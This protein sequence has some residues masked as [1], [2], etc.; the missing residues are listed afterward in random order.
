[1]AS[2]ISAL[3][4]PAE[5]TSRLDFLHESGL[6]YVGDEQAFLP[7]YQYHYSGRPA[8]STQRAHYYIPSQFNDSRSGLPGNDD[9][10]AMGSFVVLSTIGLFPV[11]GQDV[12]L[13]NPPFFEEVAIRN[14]MTGRTATI[15]NINFDPTYSNVYIQDVTR[16]GRPWTK[17][18]ISHDFFLYGG[19]LEIELGGAE[20]AWGSGTQDL[21]PS[22]SPYER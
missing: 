9:S 18:W 15:R 14:S 19:L 5:F 21:P 12:Y 16:D 11:H 13:I 4:G 2:L 8:L 22:M 10:G 20:S 17:N 6:L 3:G 7:A 1:M